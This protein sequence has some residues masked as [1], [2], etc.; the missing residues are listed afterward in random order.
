MKKIKKFQLFIQ[1]QEK[2]TK[3]LSK[4]KEIIINI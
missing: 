1:E 4:S 2:L 3:P